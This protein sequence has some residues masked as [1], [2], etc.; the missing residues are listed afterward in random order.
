MNRIRKFGNK[1]QVLIT[2]T[3]IY[4]PSMELMLGNWTD[5]KLRNYQ[6]I[7]FSDL[8]SAQC[9]ALKWPDIDWYKLS[10]IHKDAYYDIYKQIKSDIYQH[11]FMVD[12]EGKYSQPDVIKEIMFD[13]VLANGNRFSLA[14]NMNDIIGFHI[15]NPWTK[16]L[17]ELSKI[18]ERD[19]MLKIYKKYE[20][21]GVITLIGITDVSTSYEIKLWPTLL[22][23]WARWTYYNRYNNKTSVALD[24]LKEIVMMQ[25][26]ID[27]NFVIR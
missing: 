22:S 6:V 3:F 8:Q 12:I 15:I 19:R 24:S 25:E 13:R 16:N 7:D 21:H 2:P 20:S 10:L 14:Y 5:E 17:E 4:S 11:K 23:Q 26:K 27:K 18:L 1:Y 9:E